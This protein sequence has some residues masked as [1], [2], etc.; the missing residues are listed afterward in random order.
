MQAAGRP[1]ALVSM[2]SFTPVLRGCERPWQ[3][4]VLWN[5]DPRLPVPLMRALERHGLTVGDNQPYSGRGGHGY[6][7]HVHAD[8]R[9]L[10]NALI[11]LR[12]DLIDTAHGAAEWAALVGEVLEG[13]LGDGA[14]RRPG[15]QAQAGSREGA[16]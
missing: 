10:A 9:G 11:E 14:L 5:R 4:G 15:W 12:Q 2:H 16:A 1:P 3:V 13:V 8:R 7:Q 6:S